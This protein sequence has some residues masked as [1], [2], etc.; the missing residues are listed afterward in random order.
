MGLCWVRWEGARAAEKAK[1]PEH[2]LVRSYLAFGLRNSSQENKGDLSG[3]CILGSCYQGMLDSGV[4]LELEIELEFQWN[5]NS[6][7]N[8]SWNSNSK[9]NS[10]WNQNSGVC[11]G[12]SGYAVL[13]KALKRLTYHLVGFSVP[14]KSLKKF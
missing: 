14:T 1:V 11:W 4:Q 6:N 7:S 10:R 13:G 2:P 12:G 9:S 8:S 3:S 5:S